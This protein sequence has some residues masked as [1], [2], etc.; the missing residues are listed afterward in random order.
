MNYHYR[1]MHT[2]KSRSVVA[3]GYWK[4]KQ[5]MTANGYGGSFGDNEMF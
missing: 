5:E 1:Q 3:R 2:E 4:G